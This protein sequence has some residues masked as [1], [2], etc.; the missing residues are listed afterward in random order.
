MK[1]SNA[2]ALAKLASTKDIELLN[3]VFVEFL[4]EPNVKQKLEIMEL[5]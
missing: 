4:F 5:E 3:A 2:D 1:N